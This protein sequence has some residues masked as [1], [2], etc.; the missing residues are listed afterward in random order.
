MLTI[1]ISSM[2]PIKKNFETVISVSAN[3]DQR[4]S[5]DLSPII[6]N[7]LPEEIAP[8]INAITALFERL[9]YSFQR[10]KNFPIMPL[11]N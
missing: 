5:D 11:M 1:T 10:E 6:F 3:V 9:S 7:R 8:M 2:M 4:N